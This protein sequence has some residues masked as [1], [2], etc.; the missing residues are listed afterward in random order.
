MKAALELS[1]KKN[2]DGLFEIYIRIAEGQKKRRIKANIAVTKSQFKSKNHNLAWVRNHPNAK[3]LNSDLKALIEEYNDQV[4]VGSAQ[5]KVLTPE[6]V[7]HKVNKK[8]ESISL[9]KFFEQ[10]ISQMLEYNQ[11]KGYV[12]VLNNWKKY[13]E[14][15]KLGEL[16]FRQIDIHI[17][18]GFENYLFK[19]GLE[20]S[21]VYSN[22]KRI[23]SC[24]NMAIKEQVLG[25]GDYIFRAYSMPK[26]RAARKEKLSVEELRA[27]MAQQYQ[28]DSLIKTVQQS[29]LL[30][31]NMAGVRIEDV[32]SLKWENV[33]KERIEYEMTKTGALNSFQITPQIK[34]ILNYFRSIQKKG[35][36]LII[37]LLDEKIA[38][39]KKS[40]DEKENELYKKEVSRKTA[41]VNKY[42]GKIGKDAEIEKKIS[43]HISRHTFASIA[44][45]K[46]N[47]DI[48][49]VQNALKHSNPKITQVYL[50]SLDNDSM[51]EK[52]GSVTDLR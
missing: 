41:L 37:P 31:F 4:F 33:K 50:A 47:G 52:M 23:R 34:E 10:K 16:D 40:K 8:T 5:N 39:L 48:N 17:L 1:S 9:I 7:I 21:T 46:S 36:K 44:I 51:D 2:R 12:Q 14:K 45:L 3:S 28:E 42:L 11:R 49:F 20:S 35:S 25:V 22:L 6:G 26:A 15:E 30:A 24:F 27:F 19:K 29:F 43:S 18:K 13:T 32:L 38:L